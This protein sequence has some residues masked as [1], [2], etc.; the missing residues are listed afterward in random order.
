MNCASWNVRGLGEASKSMSV[1]SWLQQNNVYLC[2]LLETRA[3]RQRIDS[4]ASSIA[5][6]WA[7][8]SNQKFHNRVCI[9]LGWDPAH[10]EVVIDQV[11]VQFV[12]CCIT[13]GALGLGFGSLW[14]M[15]SIFLLIGK[16]YGLVLLILVR[17]W[18]S[19]DV[20]WVT[21][22]LSLIFG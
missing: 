7:W 19:L 9:L 10:L 5:K 4:V 6:S 22:M 12:H 16:T 14:F 20:L 15:G 18:L 2:G 3:K 11:H 17:V 21:S 1:G 13:V 8:S